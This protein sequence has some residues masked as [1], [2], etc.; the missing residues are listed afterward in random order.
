MQRCRGERQG[1]AKFSCRCVVTRHRH[2]GDL[3]PGRHVGPMTSMT[4]R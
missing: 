4:H 1:Q 3:M 2:Y